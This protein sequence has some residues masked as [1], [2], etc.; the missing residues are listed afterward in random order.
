MVRGTACLSSNNVRFGSEAD[1]RTAK[2]RAALPRIATAKADSRKSHIRFTS[3]SRHVR[4]TSRCLLRANRRHGNRVLDLIQSAC[5]LI[6][7]LWRSLCG[8]SLRLSGGAN[9]FAPAR[10]TGVAA[11][12][13]RCADPHG[14]FGA[15]PS[16]RPPRHQTSNC[17]NPNS[18]MPLLRLLRCIP[19][20]YC[21]WF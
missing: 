19:T 13:C 5:I 8:P 7:G 17:S 14:G 16:R 3:K 15:K 1:G 10:S 21:L 18:S 9:G 12:F 6:R 2:R 4:C 20:I 11:I